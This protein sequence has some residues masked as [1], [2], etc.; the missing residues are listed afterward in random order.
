MISAVVLAAGQSKRMCQHKMLLPWGKSTVIA[1]IIS[2]L[3][4]AGVEDI[5]IVVGGLRKQLTL[6]LQDYP[7]EIIYNKDYRNG[8]MLTSV[9]LGIQSLQNEPEAALIV[10]GDQ[11]QIYADII[12]ALFARYVS[13][14]SQIIVPSY[15]MRRGHPL[16][17]ARSL[18]NSLLKLTPPMTL[19]D[20]LEL[21]NELIDYLVVDNQ[22]VVQDLDTP[23]DYLRYKP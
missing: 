22:S 23:D 11:P 5:H 9:K 21:N 13:S 18:W 6:V 12:Q 7:L 1:H 14:N 8:E 15:K 17:I 2:T 4:D 10:L 20:F 16:L 3:M 19:R